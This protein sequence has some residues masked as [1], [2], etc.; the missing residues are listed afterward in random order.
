MTFRKNALTV[1]T[2]S[3]IVVIAAVSL[4]SYLISHRMTASFEEGQFTL[5]EQTLHS[6]LL[7]AES[8]AIA[9]AEMMA[10]MPAVKKAFA[11][12]NR[13]ELLS[14]TKNAFR[15]QHEK[16]GISQAQFQ[17]SPATSFLRVHNPD[18]F[19]E[20]QS[21][22][23]PMIVEVNANQTIR[24]GIEITTSGIGVFGALPMTDESGKNIGSFEMAMEIGPLLDELKGAYGFDLGFFVDEKILHATATSL[25]GDIFNDENRVGAFIKFHSTHPAL[26]QAL[27]G[28]ADVNV[29]ESA[30]YL[31]EANGVPYGVLLQPVYN[32]AKK[33]I[34]VMAIASDFSQTRSADGQAVVWQ[35]LLG[36]VSSVLLIGFILVVV[37]GM[38]MRPL[39]VLN[40]HVASLADGERGRDLPGVES[41]CEE[42][43]ELAQNCERLADRSAHDKK[44][45]N[46]E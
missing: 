3:V 27:V 14:A 45:G 15:I 37:R 20:D 12:R 1:M 42:M 23:R 22:Y 9:A 35:V 21:A 4:V 19:G 33:R 26:L 40:E 32:Y 38:I 7:G 29:T 31:R 30:H 10:A 5:M 18:K 39:E 13:A 11:A 25:K 28:D 6:K 17:L 16:Y 41:W 8:K 44:K 2:R 24:K 46:A 34:G 43:R 36:L